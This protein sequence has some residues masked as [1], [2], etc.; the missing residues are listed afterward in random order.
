MFYRASSLPIVSVIK[1][2]MHISR[3]RFNVITSRT[4]MRYRRETSTFVPFE[5]PMIPERRRREGTVA[6]YRVSRRSRSSNWLFSSQP[7]INK[8]V[9]SSSLKLTC[10]GHSGTSDKLSG[11][12]G[13]T[14]L[15]G[16]SYRVLD[17]QLVGG[18]Q[19]L[20]WRALRVV[21][22]ATVAVVVVVIAVDG[23]CLFV[24]RIRCEITERRLDRLSSSILL[25]SS[26][27]KPP[28]P[29]SSFERGNFTKH[30][31]NERLCRIEF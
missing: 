31:F 3:D 18:V 15:G 19:L 27:Q 21:V 8:L 22:A 16:V 25:R 10:V 2:P 30:L 9:K 4:I 28:L 11:I 7:A 23:D 6:V 24:L 12:G 17:K 14:L 1:F 5:E 13:D 20:A 26:F 29:G